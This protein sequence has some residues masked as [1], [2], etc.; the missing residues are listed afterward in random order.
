[1]TCPICKKPECDYNI[2]HDLQIRTTLWQGEGIVMACNEHVIPFIDNPNVIKIKKTILDITCGKKHCIDKAM[3]EVYLK[4][5]ETHI[6]AESIKIRDEIP[7]L[8]QVK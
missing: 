7:L 3:F 6:E 8:E 4:R 1:M 5:P 2:N